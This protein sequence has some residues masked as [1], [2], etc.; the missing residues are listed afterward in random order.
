MSIRVTASK[1]VLTYALV[2]QGLSLYQLYLAIIFPVCVY[3]CLVP[4]IPI[5]RAYLSS[6]CLLVRKCTAKEHLQNPNLVRAPA[7]E[8]LQLSGRSSYTNKHLA[9]LSSMPLK[10][11]SLLF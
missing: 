11:K 9:L 1:A 7:R 2:L 8:I 3:V 4:L 10:R 6:L 5:D